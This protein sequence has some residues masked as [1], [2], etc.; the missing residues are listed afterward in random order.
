MLIRMHSLI[1]IGFLGFFVQAAGAQELRCEAASR[2]PRWL[3]T[4]H[5][6]DD[7]H[8]ICRVAGLS[9]GEDWQCCSRRCISYECRE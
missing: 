5:T 9:C 4:L 3:A 8:L 2:A 7:S 1:L 6:S